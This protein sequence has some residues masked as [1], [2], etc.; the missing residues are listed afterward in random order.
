M[1][2]AQKRVEDRGAEQDQEDEPG[3]L[4]GAEQRVDEALSPHAAARHRDE[5]RA[6]RPDSS[7]FGRREEA[8]IDAAHHEDEFQED[9]P[10]LD[11]RADPFALGG[12]R[13]R[14]TGVRPATRRTYCE[15]LSISERASATSAS[16]STPIFFVFSTSAAGMA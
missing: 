5:E 15:C 13:T 4:R 14:G 3:S 9:G 7:A 16:P 8:Y 10:D 12:P 6:C 1:R 11:Q 2:E